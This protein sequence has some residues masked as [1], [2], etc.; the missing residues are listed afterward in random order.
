MQ[1]SPVNRL[2]W[3]V[4]LKSPL[5]EAQQLGKLPFIL[6]LAA[7]KLCSLGIAHIALNA[8]GRDA[9]ELEK[10]GKPKLSTFID[11]TYSLAQVKTALLL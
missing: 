1:E 9:D 7:E 2:F 10:F 3:T 4:K 11:V 6:L 8:L 5:F